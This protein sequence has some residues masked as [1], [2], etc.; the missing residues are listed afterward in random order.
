MNPKIAVIETSKRKKTLER[1]LRV[2]GV[3]IVRPT[4]AEEALKI[5]AEGGVDL[6]VL[7]IAMPDVEGIELLHA[8]KKATKRSALPMLVV[9]Q[10][11][12]HGREIGDTIRRFI[13][14]K[15]GRPGAPP[16]PELQRGKRRSI[17]IE[18]IA[19]GMDVS[20][21]KLA[22]IIDISERNLARWIT[23]ETKPRGHR[24]S[25]LQRLKS[26]YYLLTRAF[27]EETI[28]K[29]LREPNPALGGRTPLS[30]LQAGDFNSIEADLQQLI[31]GVYV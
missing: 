28:P 23:G 13:P 22:Q 30:V 5:L 6:I 7:D 26:L 21:A 29:Y 24:D 2:P 1:V 3:E 15:P 12:L 11:Y 27:K 20:R 16:T 4:T 9:S 10:E 31:E 17:R 19:K 25:L 14:R 18:E 8:L